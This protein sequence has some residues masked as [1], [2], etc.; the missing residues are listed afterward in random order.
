MRDGALRADKSGTPGH[1]EDIRAGQDNHRGCRTNPE[2]R[3]NRSILILLVLFAVPAAGQTADQMFQQANQ[4]Y[5]Q[6]KFREA[7]ESYQKLHAAGYGGVALYYNLGNA[8]YKTGDAPHAILYYERAHRLAPGDDDLRHNLQLANLMLT[9][10]IE[11]APRLFLLDW[12]DGLKAALSL[13]GM[14]IMV[15]LLFTATMGGASGVVLARSYRARRTWFLSA[16]V[17]GVLT[18]AGGTVLWTKIGDLH[19]TDEAVVM[20][21]I[22]TLKNSPD[23]ASSDAFVLHAGVKVQITDAVGTWVKIRLVDGKVGWMEK[24]AA[25]VI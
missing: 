14:T 12:W 7:L 2:I 3:M 4:A 25:E 23:A 16:V 9:D 6:G 1:A 18:I 5:Q 8:F 19:R 22:T 13:D 15:F 10:K 11:P 17:G 24:D 21:G 20:A